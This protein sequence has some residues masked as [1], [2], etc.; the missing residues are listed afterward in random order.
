MMRQRARKYT[1]PSI[2]GRPTQV[3]ARDIS[4]ENRLGPHFTILCGLSAM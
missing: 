1:S 4:Q 2:G 3:I